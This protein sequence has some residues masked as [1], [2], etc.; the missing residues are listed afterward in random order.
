MDL[1]GIYL[2]T[3]RYFGINGTQMQQATLCSLSVFNANFLT[4]LLLKL[5][6]I[7]HM[8]STD[9][10]LTLRTTEDS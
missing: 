10:V 9:F 7:T 3:A 5:N 8:F 6:V 2:N 1:Y 4:L